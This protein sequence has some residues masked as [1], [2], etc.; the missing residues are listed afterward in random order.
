MGGVGAVAGSSSAALWAPAALS[1]L[2][3]GLVVGGVLGAF[4]GDHL[5]AGTSGSRSASRVLPRPRA[6]LMGRSRA[7]AGI[8]VEALK[9]RFYPQ[10]T[11]DTTKETIEWAKARIPGAPEVGLSPRGRVAAVPAL[12]ARA[13]RRGV[14]R[15]EASARA[16]VDIPAKVKRNP[17]KAAGVA[18]GAASWRSA[19]RGGCSGARSA[20][21]FGPEE[22]LPESMLPK[23]IDDRAQA[24]GTDGA[25]PRARSS[26]S[27]RPTCEHASGAQARDLRGRAR[28]PG[29]A[30]RPRRC[31]AASAS[32][33]PSEVLSDAGAGFE[34]Q[35]AQ[36]SARGDAAATGGD[37]AGAETAAARS[38]LGPAAAAGVDTRRGR[39]AEWHARRP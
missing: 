19:G 3:A 7:S 23:E 9:A 8:D 31:P 37:A 16:A 13:R 24:L 26:G 15:L 28:A 1:G 34:E 30:D 11:I 33:W 4:T 18:A 12:A 20:R 22:P 25:G 36:G 6:A 10:T 2:V 38:T 14:V 35:L 21:S 32:S 17:V 39:V 27:S 5:R 29:A